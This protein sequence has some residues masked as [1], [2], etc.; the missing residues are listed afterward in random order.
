MLYGNLLYAD[1]LVLMAESMHQLEQDFK[2]WKRA[3]ESKGLR[4]NMAKTKVLEASGGTTVVEEAKVDP[5][6]VCG[7][8]VM[9]N[10]A[11]CRLCEK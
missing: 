1:D 3:F 8:R 9:S 4:I 11:K 6:G 7:K 5:C 10:S 2:K